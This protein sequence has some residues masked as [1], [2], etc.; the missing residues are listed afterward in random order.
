MTSSRSN[1]AAHASQPHRGGLRL[2]SVAM[3]LVGLMTLGACA[4]VG[5]VSSRPVPTQPVEPVT[6]EPVVAAQPDGPALSITDR[7]GRP[8]GEGVVRIAVLLPLSGPGGDLGPQMLR[9]AE[10]AVL[11]IGTGDFQILPFDTSGTPEGARAA[12]QR[13]VADGSDLILGPLF[14]PNVAGVAEVARGAGVNVVAFTT[15]A[16]VARDN[17]LVMGFVPA[18]QVDQ[19]IRYAVGQGLRRFA[20]LAPDTPYGRAVNEATR[21]AATSNGG[22]LVQ[23]VLYNPSGTEFSEDVQQLAAAAGSFDAIMLPDSGLRLRTVAPMLPFMGLDNVQLLGTGLWD[24]A[25]VGVE[26]SLHGAI[27]AAP[28]PELRADFAR[29][30]EQNFGEEPPRLAT[31]AYDAVALAAVLSQIPDVDAYGRETLTDRNGFAG[32]DGI[33]RF[34]P[35]GV[36]ERGLAILEVTEDGS[37]VRRRAPESF[38]VAGF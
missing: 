13:A 32:L 11:D 15:D 5:N 36:V 24:G 27:Y 8:V 22:S 3:A 9:A 25:G 18:D 12:A 33:F 4:Q 14:S 1:S 29:R 38:V 16:S 35:N 7:L 23:T 30:Y 37:V 19:V 6:V 34:G 10:M 2:R 28:Q 17:A 21:N 20:V 26:R 31:L